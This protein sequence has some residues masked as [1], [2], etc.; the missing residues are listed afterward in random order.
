[1]NHEDLLE[2]LRDVGELKRIPRTGWV[3]AGIKAPESIADHSFRT[4]LLAMIL[5]DHKGLDTEKVVRMSLIHDLAESKTGDL[6]PS[7]KPE[8]HSENESNALTEMLSLLPRKFGAHYMELWEEYAAQKTLEARLVLNADRIELLVQ[9]L[10]YEDGAVDLDHF[11]G[12]QVD[13]EY[14]EIITTLEKKRKGGR[15]TRL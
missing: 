3:Q 4:A 12:I 6:T 15:Y 9:A 11:W 7:Q 10:E 5:S 14:Q 2:F 1:M 8:N 13:P